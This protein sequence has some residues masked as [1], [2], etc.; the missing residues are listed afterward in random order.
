MTDQPSTELEP[1][2]VERQ[3]E[4]LE[5]VIMHGDLARLTPPQRIDYY[6]KVCDTLGLNPFT[7]PFQYISLNGRLT[8]YPTRDATDQLRRNHGISVD[9]LVRHDLADRGIHTVTARGHDHHGRT[10]EAIGAVF[11]ENLRGE[12]LANA[13]MKAETKAKRRLTLSLAGLGMFDESELGGIDSTPVMVDEDGNIV[14]GQVEAAEPRSVTDV[15]AARLEAQKSARE[16]L[17]EP[18]DAPQGTP[19]QL[20]IVTTEVEEELTPRETPV[21][22][23]T[24]LD[25]DDL[26]DDPAVVP[27]QEPLPLEGLPPPLPPGARSWVG[28]TVGEP[29]E[30][31]LDSDDKALAY[32]PPVGDEGLRLRLTLEEGHQAVVAL[33]GSALDDYYRLGVDASEEGAR[34]SVTGFLRLVAWSKNGIPQQPYRRILAT[35][36]G[37]A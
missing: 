11:V 1:I 12:N 3:A 2:S 14:A 24:P 32:T 33:H 18:Q 27:G 22:D 29:A 6:R 16:A 23:G 10:D 36:L 30:D 7:K 15:I 19:A 35:S 5:Q 20:G 17:A 25:L 21:Y 34:L 13:L 28:T 8:L 31:T 9:S 26:P 37:L 4:V